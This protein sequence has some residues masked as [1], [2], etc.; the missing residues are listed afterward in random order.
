MR[1]VFLLNIIGD[2]AWMKHTVPEKKIITTAEKAIYSYHTE[3][4]SSS[5][6]LKGIYLKYST[7]ALTGVLS[8]LF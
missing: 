8:E 1:D 2:K 3:I 5:A 4:Q 7:Q 6:F